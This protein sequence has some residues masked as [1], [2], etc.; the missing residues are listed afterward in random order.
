MQQLSL[1]ADFLVELSDGIFARVNFYN[2]HV[3]IITYLSVSNVDFCCAERSLLLICYILFSEQAV[4]F[5]L[6]KVHFVL[7]CG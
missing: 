3:T 2:L 1:S 7:L 6:G 5:I 4:D